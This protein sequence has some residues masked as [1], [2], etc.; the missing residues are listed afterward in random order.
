MARVSC[1]LMLNFSKYACKEI[2]AI[3]SSS[4]LD[5]FEPSPPQLTLT[6]WGNCGSFDS[7]FARSSMLR[8]ICACDLVYTEGSVSFGG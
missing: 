1:E 4:I 6:L 3:R 7:R 8:K 2:Q 5:T